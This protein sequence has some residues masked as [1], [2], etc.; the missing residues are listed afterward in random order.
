[1]SDRERERER[2][3]G[4][5]MQDGDEGERVFVSGDIELVFILLL[6]LCIECI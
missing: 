3:M 1:M 6:D 5:W 4:K 2:G